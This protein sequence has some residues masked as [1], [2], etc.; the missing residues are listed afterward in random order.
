MV[1]LSVIPNLV[2]TQ[3]GVVAQLGLVAQLGGRT[4]GIPLKSNINL[5]IY[6]SHTVAD[7]RV[8]DQTGTDNSDCTGHAPSHD[9]KYQD[10]SAGIDQSDYCHPV[11][12]TVSP[13]T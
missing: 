5:Y 13:V 9:R 2:V 7:D 6:P 10:L 4:L 12:G 1:K 11:R 3:L 8:Y